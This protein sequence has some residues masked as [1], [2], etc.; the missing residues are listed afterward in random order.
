[1]TWTRAH[2]CLLLLTVLAGLTAAE[3]APATM[4]DAGWSMGNL[5]TIGESDLSRLYADVVHGA[6]GFV[7][8]G[9]PYGVVALDTAGWPTGPCS[10]LL[11]CGSGNAPPGIY[12]MSWKGAG[13]I[14]LHQ[15]Y[16]SISSVTTDGDARSATLTITTP[17]NVVLEISDVISDLRIIRPG[18]PADTR[19]LFSPEAI[20]YYKQFSGLRNLKS[21]G[22]EHE[23]LPE[24]RYVISWT[25]DGCNYLLF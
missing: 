13:L 12:A 8:K 2:R 17:D 10:L 14:S 25:G 6:R 24:G 15:A 7:A 20:A 11:S 23:P 19:E 9:T 4:R 21:S 22:V 16:G 3:T 1:M 18:L 5:G